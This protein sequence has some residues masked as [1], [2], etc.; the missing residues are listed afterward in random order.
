M[1]S[2]RPKGSFKVRLTVRSS[3][4]SSAA[5]RV[6]NCPP[7]EVLPIQR[8]SEA[9]TSRA[10]TM[11][12]LWKR[13]FGRSVKVQRSPSALDSLFSSIIGRGVRLLSSAKSVSN[14]ICE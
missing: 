2:T 12:P 14:T 6:R 11:A 4:T 13:R 1:N 5:V 8:S 3:T 7:M 9:T 10:V